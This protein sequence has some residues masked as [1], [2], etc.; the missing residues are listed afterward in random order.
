MELLKQ[1]AH[2][3]A[4]TDDSRINR[5]ASR[6]ILRTFN[7]DVQVID[8]FIDSLHD[9]SAACSQQAEAWLLDHAGFLTEQALVVKDQ[10]SG[11]LLGKLPVLKKTGEPRLMPLCAEYFAHTEWVWQD[12]D[13]VAYLKHFQSVTVLTQAE[14]YAL[15]L[16]LRIVLFRRLAELVEQIR[17]R[18]EAC[19]AVERIFS[20]WK[21]DGDDDLSELRSLLAGEGW[22][23][24]L[25]GPKMVHLLS[26]LREWEYDAAALR[27]WLA[28]QFD[29]GADELEHI[30]TYEY[31]LQAGYNMQ[32]GNLIS[33]MRG[34][35]RWNWRISFDRLNRVDHILRE[36]HAGLYPQLDEASRELL[37]KQV[38]R[39]AWACRVPESYAAELAVELAAKFQVPSQAANRA[40]EAAEGP[41]PGDQVE[42][43]YRARYAA[44]YLLEPQGI[45]RLRKEL[46]AFRRQDA[47][48]G[49]YDNDGN[50]R[51][52][53][54]FGMLFSGMAVVWLALTIWMGYGITDHPLQWLAVLAACLFPASEWGVTAAHW[55]IGYRYKPLPL[56]RSEF[57]D[58]IPD[59]AAT[60]VVVPVIWS[61]ADEVDEIMDRLELHYTANHD[62]HIR[63]A[64]LSDYTDAAAER[65]PGDEALTAAAKQ[66]IEALNRKYANQGEDIFYWLHRRRV[67][68]PC[69][70]TWMGW[71]RK[72]GKLV[73]FVEL[74]RG[75]QDTSFETV[76]GDRRV[77]SRIRYV[78][79]LDADTQLP[80]GAA[81]QMIAAMHVPYNRP[82]FNGKGTRVIEGY[83][84]LQPRIATSYKG[85]LRSRLAL[86]WSG[87][88]GIDSYSFAVSDPYQDSI[89]V[90]IFTGKGIFD[91][92]VF[93][94]LLCERIPE[95]RVLSHD[96]LEG[97]FMRAGLLADMELRDEQP[98]TFASFQKRLHRW[99]RG[100][101]QLLCW[102]LPRVC[103]RNGT[104]V[105]VD[106]SAVTR[107]QIIDNLRRSLMPPILFLLLLLG[108]TVLPGS[109]GRWLLLILITWFL[110]AI[111]YVL[112]LRQ[113]WSNPRGLA[114]VGKQCLLLLAAW[115]YQSILMIDAIVRTVYRLSVSKS[116]LLE[117]VSSAEVERSNRKGK[118]P[119]LLGMRGGYTAIALFAIATAFQPTAG[120]RLIG[121]IV[122][123]YLAAAPALVKR[124][125][126]PVAWE[127]ERLDESEQG[128]L[129]RLAGQIW[130]FF[131]DSVTEQEHW[132]PPD[133]VQMDPPNGIAHRTSPTNI[134]L[135]LASVLAA[136][137]LQLID[138]PGLILRLDRTVKTME[139]LDS[140]RGHLY[141]WIDTR[142][143][144]VLHPRYV[145]T[146][147]SGNLI[148]SL[149]AV[150]EGLAEWLEKAD[151]LQDAETRSRGERLL[152]RI[153]A[154]IERTDFTPLYEPASQL[155]TIGY[156]VSQER[157]DSGLYDLM[158][159]ESRQTSFIAIAL[160]QV[161][162]TH[163][164]KLGRTMTR[165][166]RK[167]ALVSWSGTMFEYLMPCLFMKT[168]RKTLWSE[169]CES[170][171]K[172]QIDYM[173]QREL[174]F[175]VSESGYYAFD[176]QMNYQYRAFG[177]PGL[178][179]QRGLESEEVVSPY[180]SILALP[181]AKKSV[182]G[183]MRKLE[184]IG[185]RG[186]YG[187][188]EAVD[189]TS[190]RLPN[191][192]KY[193]IINSFMA[194]HQGMSFLA[195]VNELHGGI[196]T[197]RF[198]RDKRVQ[199]A[200]PLLQERIPAAVRTVRNPAAVCR[201]RPHEP[202]EPTRDVSVREFLRPGRP[203][204][205]IELG[206]LSNGRMTT[207][208]TD[209][210]SG[211]IH[212][213][214]TAVTRWKEDPVKDEDGCFFYIRD[215]MDDRVWSPSYLPCRVPSSAGQVSFGLDRITFTREDRGIRTQLDIIV[216]SDS[217]ADIR[218]LTMK[219]NG[220]EKRILEVTTY[221]EIVLAQP[222]ADESHPAFSKLFVET[223]YAK[224][225]GCL[226]ARRR[227]RQEGDEPLW[228]AHALV[229]QH[230]ALGA[231]EIETDRSAFIGRGY[232][233]AN[234]QTLHSRLKGTVGA[235]TDPIFAMRYRIAIEP[236]EEA[237]LYAVTCAGHSKEE[238]LGMAAPF[239]AARP[240]EHAFQL[241]WI[242]NRIELRHLRLST[243]DAA[244]FQRLAGKLLLRSPSGD[245]RKRD[246]AANINGQSDLWPHGISG[247]RPILLVR[248]KH[249]EFVPFIVKLLTGC[250]YLQRMGV[251]FDL[252]LLNES[253]G[254]YHQ[255]LQDALQRVVESGYR[256]DG[257]NVR[258]L[259]SRVISQEVRT[260][261]LSV[262]HLDLRADGRS[263]KSQLRFSRKDA[264]LP[265]AFA[266]AALSQE[267]TERRNAEDIVIRES[268]SAERLQFFN[269][270]G[271]FTQDGREY[272][273][274]LKRDH[275]LPAPWINVLANPHFG[276]LVSERG[277][278][279]T[280]WRNSRECKLT[281]W[282]NDPV[283]DPPGEMGY[284]RD[285]ESGEWWTVYPTDSSSSSGFEVAHARGYSR[286]SHVNG[287]I[288]HEAGIC[289]APDDPLKV[290]EI[291]V[292]NTSARKRKLSFTY[293]AEW[294]LGV[295][296][297]QNT[298]MIVTEWDD[299]SQTLQA[300]NTY[301]EHFRGATA[302]LG[303]H[304]AKS[305]ADANKGTDRQPEGQGDVSWT[306]DRR[307]FIG[308]GGS[309][310][311]PDALCRT[312]LSKQTGAG[313]DSCGAVQLPFELEAGEE[314]RVYVTLGCEAS[315]EEATALAQA[316]RDAA[317]CRSAFER[318]EQRWDDIAGQI[319]VSTPNAEMD[320]LLNGWLIY[321]SLG[322]RMWA[323]SGFYQAGGAYGFRDQLQDSLSL[324]HTRPDLT[325]EQILLHAA[326][327]YEEGDVQHWWHEET[328]RGIRTLFSDDYLWLPYA[329]GR[330]M[331]HT[332]DG[333]ILD[334]QVPYLHSGALRDG[335]HERYEQTVV[336]PNSG[337]LYEHCL[338]TL[339]RSMQQLGEH[340]LP[341]MG[342]GDWNDG[343]S[344]IGADGRGESVWL[345]WFIGEV[346]GRF[347]AICRERGEPERSERYR[348]YR[349]QLA[350][351]ANQHGW[352][353]RWYRRAF[354]DA[355]QWIGSVG[356]DE[357]RIDAIAQSWSIISGGAP[358][359]RSISAMESFDRELVDR[360]L[361]VAKLLDPPF[362]RM[363]PSPGYIQG[364]PPG[365][366]ENGGQ[367]THGVIW[368]IIAWCMLSNGDK[369]SEL[370]HL[371]NPISHTSTAKEVRR[372]Q[373][374][375]YAMA[376]D[377]YTASP[378]EGKAGWTWYT[379]A[380]GW[381]YQAGIEW[382]LGLQ[383]RGSR[384]W[385]RPC[386]PGDWP[387]YSVR[388]KFG[389]TLY[390]I[391]VRKENATGPSVT[392]ADRGKIAEAYVDL[393]DDGGL[394]ELEF[395][396]SG[397]AE[398]HAAL[399]NV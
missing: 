94:R 194:H 17:E 232:T 105:P 26:H 316:Y 267:E 381:M 29:N 195:I 393:I 360:S 35:E 290:I 12:E 127:E 182:L 342:I 162:V 344:R 192:E 264:E 1:K 165:L 268:G 383:R 240:V 370:F 306:S 230:P 262:A 177:V 66:R 224:E 13:L 186:D 256:Q 63:F 77:F 378:H 350:A 31:R 25:S 258:V 208:V 114:E 221:A 132:L 14:V 398:Q 217:N 122:A 242:R 103:D 115:P 78:I 343:M 331:E 348:N 325:R 212:Y 187:F 354:T 52:T 116:R 314:L 209:S 36:E 126:S 72:R 361:S 15:P 340:G 394:H 235:V 100:D 248:I 49:E 198:H 189:F 44:Y 311:R 330:Y 377:V 319:E 61:S 170:V 293:Y 375:P 107:W 155:F 152:T 270:W 367:Y 226:L 291:R 76:V 322:C 244:E 108:W 296:R 272:R 387:G 153:D 30:Q 225:A 47:T 304:T 112:S 382:I 231:A 395:T 27:E 28:F 2:E 142:T 81:R 216:S 59:Q 74:L 239:T 136:R 317:R 199:A 120:L 368:S 213:G 372:Y 277:T 337:S 85:A 237:Q 254:G 62:P 60:M 33:S 156:D 210:G 191:G 184:D 284:F 163:W 364:Y 280:W 88:P 388:Y 281:P 247:D 365:I 278:G 236:G 41:E 223:E 341:L 355:G 6:R 245:E 157:K 5:R 265:E 73:E 91:V 363:S 159:S 64:V 133:N 151:D 347:E 321:Q 160:G 128:E 167:L 203:L 150:K 334:E 110:P 308:R 218:R 178:G 386:L 168:Y 80:L 288:R 276:C 255:E 257:G 20:K 222:I 176:F 385:I 391:K 190:N 285:E 193:Q 352:D 169:T 324:L 106:L 8:Q 145:S 99:V 298:A 51:A 315:K 205:A 125:N 164:Q 251:V 185:A 299:R 102:L 174:P 220:S 21:P 75:R 129:R 118:Q 339:D 104:S 180:A 19:F 4:L 357:C 197:E 181:F 148:C 243:A 56:L 123:L 283:L 201:T 329:V 18:R 309:A 289:V 295:R 84:V 313:S 374:E 147:D 214:K 227:P 376:A 65:G 234:P 266:P 138:T 396:I 43:S 124:L 261:L 119:I 10:L 137:D 69:E 87:A 362:D 166:E 320:L 345:A 135:Y 172:R 200:E 39:L 380:A 121:L 89:G 46:A 92:D 97:G 253:E 228:A 269:G 54:Y 204:P 90:G 42:E 9:C 297:E 328:E 37:R 202:A 149:V 353:G 366:R 282:S 294:V 143:L 83:G 53:A 38:E 241:A 390:V 332:E 7:Q 300:H 238:V 134:G 68:N 55:M 57:L 349:E 263:L 356:N 79:T 373:G 82:R 11:P 301:Q 58:G 326:H 211:F 113:L 67:W 173:R 96:L 229:P 358:A 130:H 399:L 318:T 327:Q 48:S 71:E 286:F 188:Y 140:W 40:E 86:L 50:T 196:M 312:R 233:R 292:R 34:M 384:L 22:D 259:N 303:I 346:L 154:F 3:L 175:G 260:L 207:M 336:S 95:N 146:V 335:E 246:V 45:A 215:V 351:A 109:S 24:P 179:F 171:V 131:E 111:R 70:N 139:N 310:D 271:G 206:V 274:Q 158:A 249:Q 252:V 392:G 161:P 275:P 183:N 397:K 333:S 359:D 101:W 379:G 323:R 219:N 307:E 16:V 141:N 371:L 32:V 273:I 23:L 389:N 98:A 305:G 369:A 93:A 144:Q 287:G 117:W 279:Y 302:F 338:R 250:D